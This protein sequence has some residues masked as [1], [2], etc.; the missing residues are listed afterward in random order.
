MLVVAPQG[1]AELRLDQGRRHEQRFS[2]LPSVEDPQ[3][4]LPELLGH[5]PLDR[6]V[7]VHDQDEG[8]IP[9]AQ[10]VFRSDLVI[11]T[12]SLKRRPCLLSR[13]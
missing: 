12:L 1:V 5:V 3:G 2:V 9:L 7:V 11:S 13:A 4:L 6:H 8:R 10:C